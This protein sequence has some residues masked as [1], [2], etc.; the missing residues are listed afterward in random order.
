MP[1]LKWIS[2][3]KSDPQGVGLTP[4]DFRM[5]Y[6]L[7]VLVKFDDVKDRMR[8]ENVDENNVRG[9]VKNIQTEED[10]EVE[11]ISKRFI[12]PD[13]VQKL[14]GPCICMKCSTMIE[15]GRSAF[16][17]W[18]TFYDL[19][20]HAKRRHHN[21]LPAGCIINANYPETA[22]VRAVQGGN[23]TQ[24]WLLGTE[25][26]EQLVV[27]EEKPMEKKKPP[28]APSM[29]GVEIV[30][31]DKVTFKE[32]KPPF[33][34]LLILLKSRKILGL[35]INLILGVT[36]MSR[37]RKTGLML[38]FCRP[39]RIGSHLRPYVKTRKSIMTSQMKN[40]F[41]SGKHCQRMLPLMRL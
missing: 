15:N 34:L 8:D 20:E 19:K 2:S 30:N 1:D 37:I 17:L 11:M 10:Y 3:I 21:R 36:R 7:D 33:N 4:L 39:S 31:K 6:G 16:R 24:Y 35:D 26:K 14:I 18:D 27:S 13:R 12:I 40:C 41:Y 38:A 28:K 5:A 23:W 29:E 22:E 25:A 9:L 32:K